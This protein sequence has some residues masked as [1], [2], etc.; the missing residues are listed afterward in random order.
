L[1]IRSASVE[2]VAGLATEDTGSTDML[3]AMLDP[4][5]LAFLV[6]QKKITITVEVPK[7]PPPSPPPSPPKPA[8]PPAPKSPA[9]S[10]PPNATSADAGS[11][12]VLV[13]DTTS[14]SRSVKALTVVTALIVGATVFSL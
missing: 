12:A 6:S 4:N 5:K 13:A 10:P 1:A 11:D 2:G 3:T 8:P 7:S 14:G 9:S